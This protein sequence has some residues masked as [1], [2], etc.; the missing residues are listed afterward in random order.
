M[1]AGDGLF[2]ASRGTPPHEWLDGLV[3]VLRRS[4]ISPLAAQLPVVRGR[5]D[6]VVRSYFMGIRIK[7]KRCGC[8]V[9]LR[10]RNGK[11]NPLL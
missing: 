9:G 3:G 11:T 7:V 2:R 1:L 4:S 8:R 10:V 6:C 5:E